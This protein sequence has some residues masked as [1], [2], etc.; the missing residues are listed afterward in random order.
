MSVSKSTLWRNFLFISIHPLVELVYYLYTEWVVGLTPHHNN[1][2]LFSLKKNLFTTCFNAFHQISPLCW[3]SLVV[4]MSV[5]SACMYLVPFPCDSPSGANEVQAHQGR[6]PPCHQYPENM[7]IKNVHHNDWHP[8]PYNFFFIFRFKKKPRLN[9]SMVL[10]LLSALV[11]RLVVS[12][13]RVFFFSQYLL[14]CSTDFFLILALTIID[15][16]A[17]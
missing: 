11:E 4:A 12:R 6:L 2:S 8:P 3:F 15:Y 10:V 7:Y 17:V 16:W 13:V 14:N 9:I 1:Y 5:Y